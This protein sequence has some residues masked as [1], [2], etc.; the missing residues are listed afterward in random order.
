MFLYHRHSSFI[1]LMDVHW[2]QLIQSM[3]SRTTAPAQDPAPS[4]S[5]GQKEEERHGL[6]PVCKEGE[7]GGSR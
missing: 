3:L 1:E 7:G 5:T 2:L 6:R 4:R